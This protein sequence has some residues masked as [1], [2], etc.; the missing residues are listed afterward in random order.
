MKYLGCVLF[1][2]GLVILAFLYTAVGYYIPVYDGTFWFLLT[3]AGWL[4]FCIG[5]I[6]ISEYPY[7]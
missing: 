5:L 4:L 3:M 2:L 6:L 7:Y 1:I